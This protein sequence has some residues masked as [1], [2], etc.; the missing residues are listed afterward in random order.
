MKKMLCAMMALVLLCGMLSGC[1]LFT[2]DNKT[3]TNAPA[4][5]AA[6]TAG[7]TEAAATDSKAP[8][9][10]E[11]GSGNAPVKIS[12]KLT[13]E[14]P[15]DLDFDKRYVISCDET[16]PMVASAGDY[17]MSACYIICYAKE[18]APVAMYN[19]YVVD[20]EEHAKA[21]IDLYATQG[22]V[23]EVSEQDANVVWNSMDG[24]TMEGTLV[25]YQSY[26]MI[27][28]ATVSAYVQFYSESIGG[29][30]NY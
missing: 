8:E 18:D 29:K 16:S 25:A 6:D 1:S 5:T 21:L 30:T 9:T 19:Y 2:S 13:F 20:S 7:S 24:D 4:S 11:A 14:D 10:T 27:S 22:S 15:A 17:G 28:E 12:D 26:G 23:L 3:E